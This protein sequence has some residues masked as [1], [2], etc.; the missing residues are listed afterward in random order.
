M[1]LVD[2]NTIDIDE[3]LSTLISH[4]SVEFLYKIYMRDYETLSKLYYMFG[5]ITNIIRILF[6]D[7]PSLCNLYKITEVT[8]NLSRF[9]DLHDRQYLFD[10]NLDSD[11]IIDRFVYNFNE[12]V[13]L[14]LCSVNRR[15]DVV[16][17]YMNENI[18]WLSHDH[19]YSIARG[20]FWNLAQLSIYCEKYI[21]YAK[22]IDLSFSSFTSEANEGAYE[23][24]YDSDEFLSTYIPN[25]SIQTIIGNEHWNLLP[26]IFH[27][28][29][30]IN[31]EL[32]VCFIKCDNMKLLQDKSSIPEVI[33]KSLNNS[34]LTRKAIVYACIKSGKRRMLEYYDVKKEEIRLYNGD[35][36]GQLS[37]EVI[38][39]LR[40]NGYDF[41]KSADV[42]H[43]IRVLDDRDINAILS[44]TSSV[45]N[46]STMS[47][48]S[49]TNNMYVNIYVNSSI[50][51]RLIM[52]KRSGIRMDLSRYINV[53]LDTTPYDP[54][55]LKGLLEDHV[56]VLRSNR[57]RIYVYA[58]K[59][60]DMIRYLDSIINK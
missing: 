51:H 59:D 9:F 34:N 19:L 5:S 39:Y 23:Y 56:D 3:I 54:F 11:Y 50:L 15:L 30:N 8:Y 52:I 13:M 46:R 33:L 2:Y 7:T 31:I 22:H 1:S 41:T 10:S 45:S 36:V 6:N 55:L 14:K 40:D 32:D 47:N 28:L 37:V 16:E 58:R 20:M 38:E 57:E 27:R 49:N 60:K 21:K 18:L 48:V 25:Y 43:Y 12:F 44:T 24:G 17:R 42:T 53:V 35:F 29:N 4:M 26:Y